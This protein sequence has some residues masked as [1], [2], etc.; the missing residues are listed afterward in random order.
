MNIIVPM[1]LQPRI[2]SASKQQEAYQSES[3]PTFTTIERLPSVISTPREHYNVRVTPIVRTATPF[4]QTH[5]N[6]MQC[7]IS[8]YM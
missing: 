4:E 3:M 2:T 5:T 1:K 7:L 8:K 6:S